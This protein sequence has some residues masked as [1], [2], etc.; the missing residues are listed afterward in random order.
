MWVALGIYFVATRHGQRSRSWFGVSLVLGGVGAALAGISYQAFS[1]ELKCAGLEYCRLT[2]GY[3]VSYSVTQALSVSAMVIAVG[4]A[5]TSGRLRRGLIIYAVANAAVYV[6]ITVLAVAIPSA[7]LLSFVVLMLFALPGLVAVL[8]V[9]GLRFRRERDDLS[10]TLIIAGLFLV[11]VQVAYFG[12]GALGV[13]ATLWD[14]GDGIYFS[15]ND[16]LHVGMI[17]WI[18]YVFF[19]LRHRLRD[20]TWNQPHLK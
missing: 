13:T 7:F 6:A 3:E 9:A 4:Y 5:L 14:G 8:V 16:V 18:I 20:A 17:A 19:A 10:R 12:W 11:A 15:D 1:Y 2:N